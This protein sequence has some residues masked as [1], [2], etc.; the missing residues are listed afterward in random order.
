MNGKSVVPVNHANITKEREQYA[1]RN[2]R[3]SM[4]ALNPKLLSKNAQTIQ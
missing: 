2:K 3:V 4:M 1:S